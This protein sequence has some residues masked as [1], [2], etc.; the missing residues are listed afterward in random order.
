[1]LP[2]ATTVKHALADDTNIS[3]FVPRHSGRGGGVLSA[4]YI[5]LADSIFQRVS[6]SSPL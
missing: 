5:I 2:S 6:K 3:L 4:L 1:M